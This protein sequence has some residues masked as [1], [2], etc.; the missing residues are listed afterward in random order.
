MPSPVNRTR[1]S[2]VGL[3]LLGLLAAVLSVAALLQNRG[4]VVAE[5]APTVSSGPTTPVLESGSPAPQPSVSPTVEPSPSVTASEPARVLPRVVVI[6]DSHSVGDPASTWVGSASQRLGWGEVVNLS[7][8]GRGY[9]TTPRS[10]DFTPCVNFERS[11]PLIVQAKPD[12]VVTFGGT[13]DGDYNL[14]EPAAS[15]FKA[16]RKALPDAQIVAIS[17]VTSGDT[18]QYWLT[19]HKRNIA[20]AVEAVGGKLVDVGQPGVGDGKKLSAKAQAE[21][22]DQ[23]V[24]QLG[25]A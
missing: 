22:A 6:G 24:A 17:P 23:V 18:A 19:L 14:K 15:Y 13:A 10:C 20:A 9:V 2:V 16:L 7:S 3:V 4:S 8:P 12:I 5:P 1:L 25:A 11:I 21:I